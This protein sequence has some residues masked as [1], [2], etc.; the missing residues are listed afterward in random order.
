MIILENKDLVINN[1]V[2]YICNMH[3]E[4][5]KQSALNSFANKIYSRVVVDEKLVDEKLEVLKKFGLEPNISIKLLEQMPYLVF[6]SDDEMFK[7]L[8]FIYNANELYAAICCFHNEYSWTVYNNKTGEFDKLQ[9][10]DITLDNKNKRE[11]AI[12]KM[13]IDSTSRN[14]IQSIASILATDDLEDRIYKLKQ[15][16]I[17]ETGYNLK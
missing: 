3:Y 7:K 11:N 10:L 5:S 15:L 14:D 1:A 13:I 9:Y 4:E 2:S 16:K 6:L 8:S 17:N 12:I